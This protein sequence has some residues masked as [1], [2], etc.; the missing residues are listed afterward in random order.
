[1]LERHDRDRECRVEEVYRTHT[2]WESSQSG[3]E[4][5]LSLQGVATIVNQKGMCKGPETGKEK[6][7]K[8]MR[9]EI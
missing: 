9:L 8:Q 5:L 3:A 1:M 6:G 2:V 7:R 4:D